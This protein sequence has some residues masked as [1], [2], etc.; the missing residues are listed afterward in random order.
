MTAEAETDPVAEERPVPAA[1]RTPPEDESPDRG[2]YIPLRKREIL[3]AVAAMPEISESDRAGLCQ[4]A[5]R[6]ALLFHIDFFKD[7]E[8][9]KD[10][11]VRF[12][13]DQ[14]GEGAV[15]AAP[16]DRARFVETLEAAL[17]AANFRIL[18]AEE[19]HT[20]RDA[21]GRVSAQVRVPRDVF[22][23]VRFYA[24]GR[25]RT[26]IEVRRWFGLKREQVEVRVYDHVVFLAALLSEIPPKRLRGTRLRAGAIYLKLFRDIPH[27]DLETLYPNARVVMGLKDKLILGVPALMGGIPILIN[28]LPALTVLFLVIGFY[29]G[30]TGRVEGDQ[31]KQALAAISGLGALGGF[32]MRQ[33]VKYERQKLKY[34]KQVAENAYFN[35]MNNNAGFFDYLVGASEDSEVKEAFLAYA[36]LHLSDRPLTRPDLDARIEAWL[37]ERFEV[38]V[39]FEIEDAVGKL[40]RFG[41]MTEDADGRLTALPLPD[42]LARADAAWRDLGTEACLP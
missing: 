10:L 42:A 17:V 33:W 4:L 20:E 21:A 38:D 3:D 41:L 30:V 7:R 15:P 32:L 23:E 16:E 22:D 24:R 1:R 40:E 26:P 8:A 29:L 36:F 18:P 27:A 25:R 14:P 13:P 37:T 34:Q 5:Q 28:I 12:N 39:D 6:L 31:T 9:L 2:R 19:I 35:N 11:Y